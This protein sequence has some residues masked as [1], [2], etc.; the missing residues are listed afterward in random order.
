M[1][2]AIAKG[3]AR[4]V[5]EDLKQEEYTSS[6]VTNLDAG[7]I[8]MS[9][10]A[11]HSCVTEQD[12]SPEL[13]PAPPEATLKS[14]AADDL[15]LERCASEFAK[16][17]SLEEFEACD[18]VIPTSSDGE[19]SQSLHEAKKMVQKAETEAR[20]LEEECEIL[21]EQK[22]SACEDHKRVE[23]SLTNLAS[24][25]ESLRR[26]AAFL[27][28]RTKVATAKEPMLEVSLGGSRQEEYESIRVPNLADSKNQR[29]AEF[30]VTDHNEPPRK[31]PALPEET[32][33]SVAAKEE[34]MEHCAY[35]F[36]KEVSLE[37]F[38]G[39]DGVIP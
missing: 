3:P 7:E 17:V 23:S 14:S 28:E 35:V 10:E 32:M 2:Q 38:V 22:L 19:L 13:N 27:E 26:E 31:K 4:E 36:E 34:T 6:R 30:S 33:T 39:R 29:S 18:G 8:Q 15:A 12:E 21:R 5:I 1:K 37:E 20:Q 25:Y 24:E 9:T 16:E 11:R